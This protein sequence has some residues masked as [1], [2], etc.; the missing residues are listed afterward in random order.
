MNLKADIMK[1]TILKFLL[2]ILI[3]L[4]NF[5]AAQ[6][7]TAAAPDLGTYVIF[8]KP[9]A[10]FNGK[11]TSLKKNSTFFSIG[12]NVYFMPEQSLSSA[13]IDFGQN[14]GVGIGN[15]YTMSWE[16][17]GNFALNPPKTLEQFDPR[18]CPRYPG[19]C[20]KVLDEEYPRPFLRIIP[21]FSFDKNGPKFSYSGYIGGGLEL[22]PP[23]KITVSTGEQFELDR[24]QNAI[25]NYGAT[26]GY[27]ITQQ[28]VPIVGVGWTTK[29]SNEI[30]ISNSNGKMEAFQRGTKTYFTPSL[31]LRYFFR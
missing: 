24:S 4:P 16:I 14:F 19:I 7:T 25:L 21:R 1:V 8:D 23:M 15:G 10:V 17:E 18:L 11:Q 28:L 13:S 20:G 12:T 5:L 29:L 30:N 22:N 31:K 2:G 6:H 26:W 27:A 3:F 9:L